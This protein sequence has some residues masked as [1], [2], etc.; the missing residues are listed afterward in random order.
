[1]SYAIHHALNIKSDIE[2]VFESI[3]QGE[4]INNW[5]TLKSESNCTLNGVYRFYFTQE[6]DWYAA[7]SE[8]SKP[9]QIE[10]KMTKCSKDWEDTSFGFMLE[11]KADQVQVN[12]Y[13]S[14]W[15][16]NNFHFQ[17]TSYCWALLLKGLKDYIERGIIVPFGQRA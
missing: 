3:S 5:W 2:T 6:Y 16:E 10:I 17:H 13:H 7:V 11:R 12:F 14:D 1:M 4:H 15:Q 9:N 8:L